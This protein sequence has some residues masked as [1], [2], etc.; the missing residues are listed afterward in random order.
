MQYLL[1]GE[2]QRENN[3][4]FGKLMIFLL[5]DCQAKMKLSFGFQKENPIQIQI[6]QITNSENSNRNLFGLIASIIANNTLSIIV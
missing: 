5:F 2:S 1:S 6:F 3:Y 4:I